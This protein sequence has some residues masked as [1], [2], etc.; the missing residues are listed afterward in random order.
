MAE[1]SLIDF[2]PV[3]KKIETNLL[4]DYEL[5]ENSVLNKF[6]A[7]DELLILPKEQLKTPNTLNEKL[8]G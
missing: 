5:L 3:N 8:L 4:Y 7:S 6:I 1:V 2:I